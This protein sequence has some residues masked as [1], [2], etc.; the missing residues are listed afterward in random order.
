[1]WIDH[2][3]AGALDGV[4]PALRGRFSL[5]MDSVVAGE[6]LAGCRG[7]PE[8]RVVESLLAPFERANRI[9]TPMH[10]DYRRAAAALS[11]LRARGKTLANPGG[12]LLDALVMSTALRIGAMVVSANVRDFAALAAR[13]PV[14]FH[15]FPVFVAKYVE[16]AS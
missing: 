14:V 9:A 11:L 1:V 6:L 2:L 5:W 8:R 10:S 13:V 12:A 3:R 15:P 4:I 7:K 16:R